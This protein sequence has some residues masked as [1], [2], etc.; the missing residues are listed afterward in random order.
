MLQEGAGLTASPG[1][2]YSL[3]LAG[4]GNVRID[5]L[6]TPFPVTTN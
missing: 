5:P 2:R 3:K 1:V 4:R 6:R